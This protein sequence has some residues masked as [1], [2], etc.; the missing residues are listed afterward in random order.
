MGRALT[1][2]EVGQLY[3]AGAGLPYDSFGPTGTPTPTPTATPNGL[4]TNLYA[5][6]QLDEASGNALDA[7]GAGL[8]L[9]NYSNPIG[10]TTGVINGARNWNSAGSAYFY[11]SDTTKFSPGSS[12]FSF[13]IWVNLANTTQG[14]ADTGLITKTGTSDQ[15]EY[16]LW[17]QAGGDKK[18]HFFCSADGTT[19]SNVIWPTAPAANTWYNITGGWDGSNVWISVNAAARVT[20]AFTGPLHQDTIGF[21]LGFEAG[22]GSPFI[23]KIDEFGFWVGRDLTNCEVSQLYNGGAGLPFSSFGTV[24]STP[25]PTPPSNP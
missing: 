16:I 2:T 19:T 21:Q 3:N 18:F 25:T 22:S 1:Q 17:Y 9:P 20:T 5:Y 7:S 15:K 14:G 24:C 10:T 23:G 4:L 12:H 11:E 13:S 6:Y 8:N